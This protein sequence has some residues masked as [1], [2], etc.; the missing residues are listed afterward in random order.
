[1]KNHILLIVLTFCLFSCKSD[2]KSDL[3]PSTEMNSEF[4]E[5]TVKEVTVALE[6]IDSS[7]VTGNILLREENNAINITALISYLTQGSTYKLTLSDSECGLI[8][9]TNESSIRS[10]TINLGDLIVDSNGNGTVNLSANKWCL[11]CKDS[12]R[13]ILG[14][15]ILL[16]SKD[17]SGIKT[18]AACGA[19]SN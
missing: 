19:I 15:S 6:S 17:D 9:E 12:S 7:N 2:K 10:N 11:S 18:I 5:S 4:L 16:T 14:K 3:K 1:M 8:N 13:N